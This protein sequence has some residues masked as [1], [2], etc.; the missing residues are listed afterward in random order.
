[1]KRIPL[2]PWYAVLL[3]ATLLPT[4]SGI[5]LAQSRDDHPPVA[6][7]IPRADTLH[8][9]VRIDPYFWLRDDRRSAP[10]VL[11]YLEAENRYT[12]ASM[13]HTDQLQ[14]T[15]YREMVGRIKETDLS[16]P[17]FVN[18]FWYYTRTVK[19]QQYPIFCRKRGT[20][21]APEEI[22]LDENAVA[23]KRPYS[24]VGVRQVSPDGNILAYTWDTTG[25]E[26]YTLMFKDLRT[27]RLM[28]DK[29]DSVNY[30][31]EWAADNRTVF[32]GRDDAAHRAYRVHRH[33]LGASAGDSVVFEDL[34]PLF[35]VDIA[36][37]K[38]Q[39][40]LFV[41]A[42]SFTSSDTRYLR[43]DQPQGRWQLLLP[44]TADVVYTVEH[45]GDDFLIRTNENAINFK[46][47]RA[48]SSKPDRA[49]WTEVVPARDS[50]LLEDL[51]VFRNHA[52]LYERGNAV[53]RIRILEL[54]TGK[55]HEVEFPEEVS[56]FQRSDNP[57]F[58]TDLV[59]FTYMS[60]V[61]PPTVYDYDMKRRS[62]TLK[63]RTEV[64]NYQ[65][66]RYATERTW[67]LATDGVRVPISLLYR[68]PL[69]RD[70]NR[71]MLLYA[72]GSY[73][74]STDPGFVSNI[75]SLVD[76]GFVYA[77]AHIRGGQEM[78]RAWYDDG[79]MLRKKNTFTDFIAAAEHLVQ[80][81]YTRS[82]RLAIRGGSAGGLLMGAVTN[83]RPDLFRAVVAD[84][85]FVDVINTML[86]A[87]IPLTTQEWQQWGNPANAPD[88]AYMKSY[89]P[90]DNVAPK[91]YPS[92][93]V[94]A[95]LND[96]RVGYWEPTKWVAKLRA[97][98][99]DRNALLLKTNMGAGHGGSSG[100]YDYLKEMAFRYAFVLD[101]VKIAIP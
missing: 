48:P 81:G 14:K 4:R 84:V 82:D 95:G 15:L 36:K 49:N 21:K 47:V 28:P 33:E 101:Q 16:V 32:Y 40:Y 27:R 78:G 66:A 54:A 43:A 24:R 34:D 2:R 23:G 55:S 56:T 89:S 29:I 51:D 18:G 38:D 86:D 53:T 80:R 87:S 26:W 59:R 60:P 94:T 91:N 61:T 3:L 37:S 39:K 41:N 68:K 1:M 9:E 58:D 30:E 57:E 71:P 83:M 12:E 46:L 70:G 64:P 10:E 50:V 6:R 17:E 69:V 25:G 98:K 11:G 63:K 42:Q 65:P 74:Y 97:T 19:G 90:Y 67:A 52:A 22:L 62:R 13:R 73:G 88:Y 85:P 45:H 7:T 96:P 93:L 92:I 44:R 8:G 99:T 79:K 75:F 20:L 72:Y 5:A 31:V 100:R 35:N 77:I 76:R